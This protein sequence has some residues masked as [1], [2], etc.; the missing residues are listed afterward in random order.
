MRTTIKVVLATGLVLGAVAVAV[1][2][3]QKAFTSAVDQGRM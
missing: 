1:A 2:V 3:A